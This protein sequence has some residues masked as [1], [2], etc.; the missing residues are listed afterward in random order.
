MAMGLKLSDRERTKALGDWGEKRA[1]ALLKGAGFRNVRDINLEF[2]NHPFCDVYAERNGTPYIIGVKTRN[3]FQ[4]SGTL[5]PTY[6]IRKRAADV[7]KIAHRYKAELAWVA[8]QTIPELQQFSAFF[9][10][11]AQIEEDGERFSIRMNP[12]YT[13]NYL[14]LADQQID[15]SLRPEWSNGGFKKVA[16]A[17]TPYRVRS[18][19]LTNIEKR[20]LLNSLNSTDKINITTIPSLANRQ[21]REKVVREF[22]N[23]VIRTEGR[24]TILVS[25]VR[26]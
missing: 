17:P 24:E 15:T 3:K 22:V 23:D 21:Q 26:R 8:I 7:H 1:L 12:E 18:T 11:I 10:T 5:N 19:P 13:R 25:V 14:R 6:N 2:P 4:V 20:Q 16:S 9:G